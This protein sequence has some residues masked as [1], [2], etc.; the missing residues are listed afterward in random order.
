MVLIF[1]IGVCGTG[2]DS[3]KVLL[4]RGL[5]SV[6][7]RDQEPETGIYWSQVSTSGHQESL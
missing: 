3:V 4:L 1:P 5:V 2:D 6:P 7:G